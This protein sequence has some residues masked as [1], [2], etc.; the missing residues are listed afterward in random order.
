[1]CRSRCEQ[2]TTGVSLQRLRGFAGAEAAGGG[3]S[4]EEECGVG[5]DDGEEKQR[6]VLHGVVMQSLAEQVRSK[7]TQADDDVAEEAHD[8]EAAG[9][10][11]A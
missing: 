4:E 5:N 7:P 9:R 6:V 1:M 8:E 2:L 10:D 11:V 3:Q